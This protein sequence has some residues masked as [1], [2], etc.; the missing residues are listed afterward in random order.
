[1]VI[2]YRRLPRFEYLAPETIEDAVALLSQH[3]KNARVLAGGTDLI[4]LLRARDIPAPEFLIDVKNIAE[5]HRLDFDR[6]TG[7][8]LGAL[9]TIH[10]LECSPVVRDE[11]A[12]LYQA[13]QSMASVQVRNRATLGGNLWSAVPSADAAPALLVLDAHAKLVGPGG[14]RTAPICDLI[15]GPKKT[16]LAE[17]EILAEIQIPCPPRGAGVYLK[18]TP[19]GAM[20]L[21]VVGVAV[22]LSLEHGRCINIRLGLGAVS[23]TPVRAREAES[24]LKGQSITEKLIAQASEAASEG[25]C[26]ISD[27]RASAEYRTEMVK[28]LTK[29]AI[30][31]AISKLGADIP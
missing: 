13:A 31:L 3:K 20:D 9:V 1:M 27:H 4:P 28:V 10:E 14:T 30:R 18:L 24:L 26:R 5:L 19:R 15:T 21:A 6:T 25:C 11:F 8:R 16:I 12:V 22:L 2:A 29:R 7:L 17:D 23:P